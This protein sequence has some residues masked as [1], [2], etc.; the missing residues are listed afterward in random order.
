MDAITTAREPS[1]AITAPT[2]LP[3]SD[4]VGWGLSSLLIG[5]TLLISS[6][7][8]LVF[9]VLLFRTGFAG[10]PIGLAQA[11]AMIGTAGV[12]MLGVAAVVFGVKS[13]A[14]AYSLR[15]S[16]ALGVAGTL[17][18]AVGLAAWLIAGIDLLMIVLSA[19]TPGLLLR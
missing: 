2:S 12:A 4:S 13:W 15:E 17:T 11:G 5:C 10:I 19:P 8:L 1:R 3:L 18:S 6:C 7:A 14:S 16:P 9:N